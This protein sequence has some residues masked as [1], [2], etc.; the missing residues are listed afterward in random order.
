MYL[1]LNFKCKLPALHLV[2]KCGT[3]GDF[4]QR[5]ARDTRPPVDLRYG[6]RKQKSGNE[7]LSVWIIENTKRPPLPS[8]PKNPIRYVFY[9]DVLINE[10]NGLQQVWKLV[11]QFYMAVA[12]YSYMYITEGMTPVATCS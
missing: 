8:P 7:L 12:M 5:D 2:I 4:Y 9:C 11:S 10:N 1:L 6:M 3:D